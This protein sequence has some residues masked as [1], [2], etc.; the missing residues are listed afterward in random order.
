[1]LVTEVLDDLGYAAIEAADSAAGLKLPQSDTRIDS[2][3][4]N[5]GLP[6]R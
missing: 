3:V 1:M 2:L 6:G 4:M 5:V